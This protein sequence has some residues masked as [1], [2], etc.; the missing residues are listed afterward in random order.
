MISFILCVHLLPGLA[1]VLK[2]ATPFVFAECQ[3]R[4]VQG[5]GSVKFRIENVFKQRP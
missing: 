5:Q 1:N 3:L 4:T 2:E